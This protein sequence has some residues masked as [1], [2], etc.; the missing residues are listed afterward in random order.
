[1]ITGK[2]SPLETEESYSLLAL[3]KMISPME[4]N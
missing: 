1:M 2:A 3:G 4:N